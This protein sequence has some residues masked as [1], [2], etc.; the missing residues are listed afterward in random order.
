MYHCRAG[1]TTHDHA[2]VERIIVRFKLAQACDDVILRLARGG[3]ETTVVKLDRH[4][5]CL[6]PNTMLGSSESVRFGVGSLRLGALRIGEHRIELIV[7][8]DGKGSGRYHWD[9]V[10]LVAREQWGRPLVSL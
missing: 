1:E 6:V 10:S 9:A 2:G 5:A 7:V 4:K 8:D 3:A